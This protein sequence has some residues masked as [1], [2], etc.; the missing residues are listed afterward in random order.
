MKK[1]LFTAFL[2][3]LAE[4]SISAA[5]WWENIKIGG[6]FRYRHE[7]IDEEGEDARHRHRIRARFNIAGEVSDN[8]KVKLQLATGSDDPVSTNQTLTDAFSTKSIGLDLAYLE[9]A[10]P[11]VAGLHLLGGK[12]DNPFYKPGSSELLWDSDFNPEGGTAVYNREFDNISVTIIGA[13][14][15]I[16]ERSSDDSWLGA[17]Q[18]AVGYKTDD[19]KSKVTFGGGYFNYVNTQGFATFYD[20]ED[21]FGNS[22]DGSGNYLNDYEL[23]EAYIELSHKFNYIPVVV[24][25]DFVTNTAADSLEN[26]WLVGINIGQAKKPGTWALRYIY[27]NIEKDAVMGAFTDSDFRGGGTDAKGHEFGGDYQLSEK[28]AFKFTYFANTIGLDA[29][30]SDFNRM[31]IDLQLKF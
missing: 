31:Q 24:M 19:D 9:Y 14:L 29:A 13:G 27:R 7:M 11:Q 15:W 18:V 6:D 23:M 12:F 10:P 2:L 22:V 5:N 4:G 16:M 1:Y 17:G 20:D 26:G 3:L 28:A 8:T 25:G 30:E 21:S